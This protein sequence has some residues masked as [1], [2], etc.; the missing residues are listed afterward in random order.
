MDDKEE[1]YSLPSLSMTPSDQAFLE[2]EWI[3]TGKAK[4]NLVPEAGCSICGRRHVRYQYEIRN[5][6]TKHRAWAGESCL[7]QS[8]IPGF[9][10][11]GKV[12]G[13]EL[14]G[15]IRDA[16]QEMILAKATSEL[17][18]IAGRNG[19]PALAGALKTLNGQGAVSPN[20]AATIFYAAQ[21]EGLE[22]GQGLIR[23]TMK[24]KKHQEQV[25]QMAP[26]LF[27]VL[28]ERLDV[29]SR[30]TAEKIRGRSEQ[31]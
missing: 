11:D 4:D 17:E 14:K 29:Q 19:H 9:I 26:N 31:Q 7:I 22:I 8:G 16:K 20:Q 21:K 23:V 30:A 12:A 18:A 6:F 24:K 25:Q 2:A 15:A 27:G 13:D 3:F 5:Q 10:G 28:I 1:L